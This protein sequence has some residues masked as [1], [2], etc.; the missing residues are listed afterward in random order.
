M[1]TFGLI[2]ETLSI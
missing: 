2:A 1:R